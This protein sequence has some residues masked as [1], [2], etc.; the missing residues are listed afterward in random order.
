MVTADEEVAM[1]PSASNSPTSRTS[2]GCWQQAKLLVL[3]AAPVVGMFGL[4]RLCSPNFHLGIRKATLPALRLSSFGGDNN[5]VNI[6]GT[7]FG[8]IDGGDVVQSAQIFNRV[9][10]NVYGSQTTNNGPQT[11]IKNNDGFVNVGNGQLKPCEGS[12]ND[13]SGAGAVAVVCCMSPKGPV[14]CDHASSG[15]GSSRGSGGNGGKTSSL[16]EFL[17]SEDLDGFE[18]R[19]SKFGVEGP[20]DL[21][22]LDKEAIK[23]LK[24]TFIQTQKLEK[25]VEEAAKSE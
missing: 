7:N 6:D 1:L 20:S 2:W 22:Y 12:G 23:A 13:G 3:A 14:G 21:R 15:S 17:E 24:G 10:K 19:L 16:K 18:D 4:L 5:G 11:N 9:K 8:D 25:A